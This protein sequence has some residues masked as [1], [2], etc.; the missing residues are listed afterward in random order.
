MIIDLAVSLTWVDIVRGQ[1]WAVERRL[2]I[3]GSTSSTRGSLDGNIVRKVSKPE[4]LG[5]T[6][7]LESRQR[8]LR[9]WAQHPEGS[10]TR[11]WGSSA[12]TGWSCSRCTLRMCGRAQSSWGIKITEALTCSSTHFLQTVCSSSS[13]L[14]VSVQAHNICSGYIRVYEM[15]ETSGSWIVKMFGPSVA[16]IDNF[17]S[18]FSFQDSG[19]FWDTYSKN[20][21]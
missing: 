18:C 20:I 15:E 13:L 12:W 14:F 3:L 16:S 2:G 19:S 7:Q 11:R 8:V 9:A 17:A 10:D 4:I 21:E 5:L 6:C 1:V